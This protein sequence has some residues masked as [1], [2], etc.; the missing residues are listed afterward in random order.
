MMDNHQVSDNKRLA[1]NT[2][3]LYCRMLL[4]IA[5]GLYTTRVVL[6]TLGAEDYGIYNVVG[7]IVAMLSFLNAAMS[8]AT[9]RFMAFELG[10][11]DFQRLRNTF[12]TALLIHAGIALVIFIVAETAGLWF[13]NAKLVIPA[14]RLA[15]ANWVYQFSILAAMVNV[16]QVPY[17]AS[18]IAHEKMTV[19]AYVEILNVSLKL[20]I[21]Y[22]LVI[23]TFDKLILYGG[24]TLCICIVII[25][26]YRGYCR[27]YFEE[28]RTRLVYDKSILVP[29]LSFFGWD[30]YGNMCV[31]AR[32]QGT[33][34]LL[35]L[36]FGP[37]ANAAS[38]IAT[39][40]NGTL[41]GF[42]YN[43]LMAARPPIIKS[44]AAGNIPVMLCMINNIS[45]YML[46]LVGA[47][48]IPI[49]LEMPYIMQLWLKNVPEY[50]VVFCR[51]IFISGCIGIVNSAVIAGIHATGRIK[52]LSLL[53]GSFFLI[54]LPVIYVFLRLG[55]PPWMAYIV[56]GVFVLPA[57]I[58]NC[59]ILNRYVPE[60]RPWKFLF[61][62]FAS[63]VCVITLSLA[64][65]VGLYYAVPRPSFGRLVLLAVAS[66]V[67][68]G[69]G[70][71]LFVMNAATR[72]LCRNY[73]SGIVMKLYPR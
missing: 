57:L 37:I 73:I 6:N 62:N 68:V 53:S 67:S 43:I 61:C 65:T 55:A 39:T 2:A 71:Y 72:R 30:L 58:A 14:D 29:M 22:L 66:V 47:I 26:V 11:A 25:F 13:V 5:I 56:H 51:L 36:F 49:L 31:T 19:Y 10:R 35:N 20:I 50:T 52:L 15:A 17:N 42:T 70:T 27:R 45:K 34:V 33:N 46:L 38:G 1:K 59:L 3:A 44:Y 7:G 69:I 23:G 4:S 12:S 21:V 16:M 60:F 9:S 48:L 64:V 41:L 18:I 28:C 63:A 40:V 32:Q 8:G 24:L 54:N